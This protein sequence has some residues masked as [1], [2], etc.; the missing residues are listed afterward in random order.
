MEQGGGGLR[1]TLQ[2]R[3]E[4]KSYKPLLKIAFNRWRREAWWG[5][6]ELILLAPNANS[7]SFDGFL[8]CFLIFDFYELRSISEV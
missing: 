5:V 6:C 8:L 7:S 1:L 4:E 2:P 3:F